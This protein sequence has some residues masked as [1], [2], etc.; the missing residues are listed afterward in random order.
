MAVMQLEE[1]R[2]KLLQSDV[3]RPP[4]LL[5]GLESIRR[6]AT[7][8]A[9]AVAAESVRKDPWKDEIIVTRQCAKVSRL[10]KASTTEAGA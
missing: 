7:S 1:R 8:H 9:A 5:K 6:R 2:A 4:L 10:K 3:I